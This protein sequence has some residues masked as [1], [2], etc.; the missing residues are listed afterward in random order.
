MKLSVSLIFDCLTES[1]PQAGQ[2]L[3]TP[4]LEVDRPILYDPALPVEAERLY[5]TDTLSPA[6]CRKEIAVICTSACAVA[7]GNV[8]TVQA[9]PG[10]V[11]NVLQRC[12]DRYDAWLFGMERLAL[13][14]G[15]LQAILRLSQPILDNPIFLTDADFSLRAES[16]GEQM[17][18]ELQIYR[19]SME[20]M[21]LFTALLQSDSFRQH[22]E[23]REPFLTAGY[24]L[25]F[26][27][28]ISNLMQGGVMT[29]QLVL[30]EYT[31][32]LRQSD[33]WLMSRLSRCVGFLLEQE[34][35]RLQSE[36]SLHAVL[37]RL[38][39]EPTADMEEISRQLEGLGWLESDSYLCAVF[40]LYMKEG[41]ADENRLRTFLEHQ[42]TDCCCDMYR[43]KIVCFFDLTRLSL[44]AD[45][46]CAQL[47]IFIRENILKAGYSRVCHGHGWLRRQYLQAISALQIGSRRRPYQWIHHFGDLG[48]RYIL[49]QATHQLPGEMVCHEGILRLQTSDRGSGTAYIQT[50]RAYLDSGCNAVQTA[51]SLFIHR[52]TLLYRLDKIRQIL[53]SDL[54]DAEELLYLSIS[55]RLLEEE[56]QLRL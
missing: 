3:Q 47:K 29:H 41:D 22:R 49:E 20:N 6:L 14:H 11:L 10:A 51:K 45:T 53:D 33:G 1:F 23:D 7:A 17:P 40:S 21:P 36:N 5:I 54:D 12:W 4:A 44:D 18:D 32:P 24:V 39:S 50:L 35:M 43:D 46:L 37:H 38:L 2:C 48:L 55:L 16:G 19:D 56:P 30:A 9:E 26:R 34:Q 42:Y 31:R 28:W 15:S 52:S 8:M 13:E 25:P 27:A